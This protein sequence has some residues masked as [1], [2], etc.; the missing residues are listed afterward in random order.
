MICEDMIVPPIA[1]E[2]TAEFPDRIRR[3]DPTRR[4]C[5][6]LRIHT[7]GIAL[8]MEKMLRE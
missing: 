1:E 6:N 4:P 2:R 8:P 7:V 3:P 5:V